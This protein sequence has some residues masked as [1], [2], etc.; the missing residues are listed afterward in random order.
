MPTTNPRLNVVLEKPLYQSIERMAHQAHVSMSLF[1]RDLVRKALE[2]REDEYL[3]FVA[4]DRVKTLNPK[5]GLTHSQV[6]SHL[7]KSKN[8]L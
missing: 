8:G 3:A 1:V 7:K 5:K 4:D 6:W 2:E